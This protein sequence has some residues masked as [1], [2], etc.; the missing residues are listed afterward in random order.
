MTLQEDRL[1]EI[2]SISLIAEIELKR[3]K[4]LTRNKISI[5]AVEEWDC[6]TISV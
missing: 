4:K 3:Q 5:N 1:L 6:C 2:L